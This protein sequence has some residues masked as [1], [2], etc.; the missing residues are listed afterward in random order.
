MK[1]TT[2]DVRKSTAERDD[3]G[4]LIPDTHTIEWDGQEAEID[5]YPLTGGLGNRIAKH[6]QGLTE[7]DPKAVAAVLS[8]SCPGLEDLRADDVRDMKLEKIKALV[9]PVVEQLPEAEVDPGNR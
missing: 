5:V 3:N 2:E 8:A 1:I 4:D 9:D 6:E 7:L